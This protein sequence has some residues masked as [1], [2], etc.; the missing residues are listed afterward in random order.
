VVAVL[1]ALLTAATYGLANYLG[2]LLGRRLPLAAVLLAGQVA[3]LAAASALFAVR[4]GTALPGRGLVLAVT[5]GVANGVALA[6]F[7]RGA[8]VGRLSVLAPLGSTGAA[9]PVLV[10]LA[11]G[12][13]P[14]PLQLAGV[15]LALGGVALAARRNAAVGS[16]PAGRGGVG[17]A[18]LSALGLGLFLTLFARASAYG[19]EAAL[20]WSRLALLS[21]TAAVVAAIRPPVRVR[22]AAALPAAVPGLLLVTGTFAYGEATRRG[23]LSVVSVIATLNPVVTVALA[24]ALLGER[25]APVQRAGVGVALAGVVLLAAG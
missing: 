9:V 16:D 1:L 22:P 10:S 15:P 4:G 20:F 17:W 19:P 2:P 18:A 13:R 21:A 7:Y 23:L 6:A 5:A 11:T 24:L 8:Q 14:A 3:A 25:L 12:E